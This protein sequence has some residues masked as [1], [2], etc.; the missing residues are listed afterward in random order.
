MSWIHSCGLSGRGIGA[1]RR[2]YVDWTMEGGRRVVTH[3]ATIHIPSAPPTANTFTCCAFTS[4]LNPCV[5]YT[6]G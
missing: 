4:P 2:F 6:T 5:K 1:G 3:Q